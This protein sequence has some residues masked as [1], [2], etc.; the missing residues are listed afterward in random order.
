MENVKPFQIV[1]L[2]AKLSLNIQI[3]GT[4]S[5]RKNG[6]IE[7]YNGINISRK[8]VASVPHKKICIGFKFLN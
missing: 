5:E 4:S 1:Y 7:L 6:R 3:G 8:F 2:S